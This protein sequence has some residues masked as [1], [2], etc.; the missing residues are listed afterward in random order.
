MR[1]SLGTL[2]TSIRLEGDISSDPFTQGQVVFLLNKGND[3][4]SEIKKIRAIYESDSVSDDADYHA[5][6]AVFSLID[7]Y[8]NERE[9][10]HDR[11]KRN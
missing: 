4:V 3:F 2:P 6:M 7:N 10:D 11:F 5:L 8:C 1:K 9:A